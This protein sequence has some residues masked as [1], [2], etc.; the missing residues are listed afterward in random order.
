MTK[1]LHDYF[2]PV[3]CKHD[4]APQ[5]KPAVEPQWL[6]RHHL[7]LKRRRLPHCQATSRIAGV[8]ACCGL[9]ATSAFVMLLIT[10][11]ATRSARWMKPRRRTHRHVA[12]DQLVSMP[13]CCLIEAS[14]QAHRLTGIR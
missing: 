12:E 3:A 4:V 1:A 11:H 7:A 2:A 13:D 9:Y 14:P 8:T 10:T 6:F 5:Q